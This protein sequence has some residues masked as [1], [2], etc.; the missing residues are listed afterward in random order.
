MK[1]QIF[2]EKQIREAAA[3]L[4]QGEI[5]AFPTE[6][7]YGLGACLYDVKAVEKI[8]VAKGRPKAK[9]L[10]AHIADLQQVEELAEE[11]PEEFYLL[12]E[13]FFPGPL[14]LILKKKATIPDIVSAGTATIGIRFPDHRIA[15]ELIKEVGMPLVAPSA[16]TSGKPSPISSKQVLQDLE[17]KIAA[18]IDGGACPLGID[19]TVFDLV[20]FQILRQGKI[21]KQD[22]EHA[23]SGFRN[24]RGCERL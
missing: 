3:L 11:I 2:S 12:A 4:K 14:T 10:S 6:T 24:A 15:Q 16:N 13:R 8:Y 19:S 5:V 21:S 20:S 7:V 23:C 9:P 1:T 22:I 18:V 17:G